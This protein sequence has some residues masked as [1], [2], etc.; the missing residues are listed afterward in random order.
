MRKWQLLGAACQAIVL[1]ALLFIAV[2]RLI[3]FASGTAVFK[4]QGY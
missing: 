4:Y 3:V 1:G 2:A